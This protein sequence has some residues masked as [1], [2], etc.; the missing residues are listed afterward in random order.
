[1]Y[2]IEHLVAVAENLRCDLVCMESFDKSTHAWF[3]PSG[4]NW[5]GDTVIAR[6]AQ[7]DVWELFRRN[8]AGG[9]DYVAPACE[10]DADKVRE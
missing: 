2:L 8:D 1:M 9:Y 5:Y 10:D 4:G 7:T 6:N 3:M